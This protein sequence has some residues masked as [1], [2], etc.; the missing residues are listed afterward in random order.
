MKKNRNVLRKVIIGI[1]TLI[2]CSII[3]AVSVLVATRNRID[4]V[5][6]DDNTNLNYDLTQLSYAL[7]EESV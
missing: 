1:S 4:P 6:P 5:N 7:T 3:V 2:C